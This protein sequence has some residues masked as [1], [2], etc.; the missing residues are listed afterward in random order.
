MSL[1][2]ALLLYLSVLVHE[3]S[4]TVVALRSGLPVRRI[5][6]HLLGGVSEIERPAETPG[7]EAGIAVAGPAGLAAARRRS[8]SWSASCSSPARS[9]VSSPGALMLEQPAGRRRST[10]CPACRWTAAGCCGGGLAGHR[11]P[12]HRHGRRRLGRAAAVAVVV[13]VA[14]VPGRRAAR[15]RGLDLVDVIWAALLGAFIWVGASQAHPAGAS[16]QQRL[17]GAVG[18][19]AHPAGGPGGRRRAAGRGAAPARTQAGARGAGRRRRG[20]DAGRRSCQRGRRRCD[21]GERRPWV[22][23]GD[24]SPAARAGPAWSRPTSTGE[25]LVEAITAHPA[26][27]YLVVEATGEVYGVLATA[28]VERAS[29]GS[30]AGRRLDSPHRVR[31]APARPAPP[32]AAARSPWATGSSSPTPRAGCTRSPWWPARSSTPTRARSPTT[33]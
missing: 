26:S 12:A 15:P 23:V 25:E 30:D 9:A 17:P 29:P 1:A 22:P 19:G 21:P 3:L 28:D 7:R 6:L 33:T 20:G 13:L 11:S 14:A 27:E 4:H 32:T 10:C 31:A 8:P 2:F 24:L 5:S 18:P 16:V